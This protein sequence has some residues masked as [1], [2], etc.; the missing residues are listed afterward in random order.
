MSTHRKDPSHTAKKFER[1]RAALV[2]KA[3]EELPDPDAREKPPLNERRDF[4]GAYHSDQDQYEA[5]TPQEVVDVMQGFRSVDELGNRIPMVSKDPQPAESAS[6]RLPLDDDGDRLAGI[7]RRRAIDEALRR[8][9][10]HET[11]PSGAGRSPKGGRE[12]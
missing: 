7:A 2:N 6:A 5:A 8:G 9:E 4:G 11:S 1:R 10:I 3:R 12:L